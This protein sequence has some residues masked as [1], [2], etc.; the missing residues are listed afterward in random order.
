MTNLMKHERESQQL[1]SISAVFPA[2]N[3]GGTIASMVAAAW[4]ALNQVTSDYEIIVVNDGSSDYTATMLDE[5][6]VRYPELRVITHPYNQGY[7]AALRTGFSAASKDWVFYTDGDSQYNPLELVNLVGALYEGVDVV[8]GYKLTRNDSWMRIVIGRAYHYLVKFLF[9]IHIRD[10]DC[11]FRLIPRRILEE[12][13]LKSVSGAIC[14]ELVKKIEDAGYVFAEVP[15]NHYSRKYGVSQ[16]F[17]PWRIARTLYQLADLYW[18]L[19]IRKEHLIK[20]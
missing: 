8:N 2:Y 13:E 10:V 3:D 18:K 4:I 9:G 15:V 20:R 17:V 14:L 5:I 16:F 6:S 12:I 1:P 11:D 19:V 7:G